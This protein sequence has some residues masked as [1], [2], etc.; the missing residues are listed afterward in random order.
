MQVT[1][2]IVAI[3]ATVQVNDKFKKREF[4]IETKEDVNGNVYS[5]YAKFQCVQAKCDIMDRFS[6]G[7]Q[8]T[9]EFNIKGNRWEKDGK[10]NYITN[11]D[12][13]RISSAGASQQPA[14]VPTAGF[15]NPTPIGGG[16]TSDLPF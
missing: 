2:T 1:G 14:A 8:V 9:V 7:E 5:N 15:Y 16:D 6:I 11:L 3:E 12:A 13:W 10:V 4:V